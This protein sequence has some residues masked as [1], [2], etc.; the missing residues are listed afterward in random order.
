MTLPEVLLWMRLKGRNLNGLKFRRQH[1]LGS[2]VLDF[3]CAD[4]R[5][6]VEV[7]GQAH[8][9]APQIARDGVR[10]AWLAEHGVRVLRLRAHDVL[11]D[12]DNVVVAIA[13]A[14][15]SPSSSPRRTWME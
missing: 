8:D 9:R 1:P 6:A 2:Y 7:D 10:D 14:A 5:L 3:F 12:L 13:A 15:V 4:R 11:N